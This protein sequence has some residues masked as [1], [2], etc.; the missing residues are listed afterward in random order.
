M[1]TTL[2]RSRG[3]RRT[4]LTAVLAASAIG[5]VALP[6]AASAAPNVVSGATYTMVPSHTSGSIKFLNVSGASTS[7]GA[8]IVQGSSGS[9]AHQ[10]FRITQAGTTGG[11]P[12]FRIRPTHVS[13]MCFDV[14]GA[15]LND[16]ARVNQ[17]PCISGN[18][19]Q[20]FFLDAIF[21]GATI[22]TITPRHSG[23]RLDVIGASTALGAGLQQF[24]DNGGRNQRF[25][26]TRVG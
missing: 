8:R 4:A 11:R 12:Y 17:F 23:K 14:E 22:H 15:S 2:V 24:T 1:L 21:P 19:N 13:N 3:R 16:G 26:L 9:Q 7:A 20:Q 5:A 10:R 18:R 25:L 6:S